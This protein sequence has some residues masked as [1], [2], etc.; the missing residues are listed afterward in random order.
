MQNRSVQILQRMTEGVPELTSQRIFVQHLCMNW[1]QLWHKQCEPLALGN[2][3]CTAACASDVNMLSLSDKSSKS[4]ISV[5]YLSV[6]FYN[7]FFF[8]MREQERSSGQV[9][10]EMIK[11]PRKFSMDVKSGIRLNIPKLIKVY[12]LNP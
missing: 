9:M 11:G 7:A 10:D 2:K 8:K 12:R 6:H 1:W 3:R 4:P 5:N